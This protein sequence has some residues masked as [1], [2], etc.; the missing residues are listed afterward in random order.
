MPS[1][2]MKYKMSKPLELS[3]TSSSDALITNVRFLGKVKQLIPSDEFSGLIE[4]DKGVD[5]RKT[6]AFELEEV[7]NCMVDIDKIDM[8]SHIKR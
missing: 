5:L 3:K 7:E 8:P 1:R 2:L 4:F 6:I